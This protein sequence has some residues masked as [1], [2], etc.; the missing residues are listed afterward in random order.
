MTM[1]RL[2]NLLLLSISLALLFAACGDNESITDPGGQN[3][4]ILLLLENDERFT[5][6][7]SLI[8]E[9]GLADLMSSDEL[10]VFAPTNT[11]FEELFSDLNPDDF[12]QEDVVEIVRYHLLE[13]SINSGDLQPMQE[14]T[15]LNIGLIYVQSENDAILINGSSSVIE[16]DI[17]A[18]NGVIHSVDKVFI[19][20]T[21]LNVIEAAQKNYNFTT[22]IDLINQADLANTI[23]TSEITVFVPTNDAFDALFSLGELNLTVEEITELVLYHTIPDNKVL[24]SN[25]APEQTVFSGTG[26]ELYITSS[27]SGV[28]V[29]GFKEVISADVQAKNGVMHALNL[30]L[31]PNKYWSTIGLLQKN[32]NYTT[33]LGL[34]Y[35]TALQDDLLGSTIFAPTNDAFDS[36]YSILEPGSFNLQEKAELVQYHFIPGVTVFSADFAPEQTVDP[37]FTEP[38]YL[39]MDTEGVVINGKSNVII[40]DVEARVGVVHAVDNV[41]LPN[42]F[43]NVGDILAKNYNLTDITDQLSLRAGDLLESP[44][45]LTVF[46]PAN[47]AY[48]AYQ[49][50]FDALTPEQKAS[51][52]QYH[53]ID[54]LVLSTELSPSQSVTM[55]NDQNVTITASN[56]IITIDAVNSTA[57]L[58][59]ADLEGLNGVVHII[60]T[61]LIPAL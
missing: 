44:G 15:M 26:E 13:G 6:L 33:F 30:P 28:V 45:P 59:V 41:L 35:Q 1:N 55:V 24:T 11:A 16:P 12:T 10:T 58:T 52:I 60:D 37:A 56:G 27:S 50:T 36:L 47:D 54:A 4:D 31:L 42:A 49:A 39:T 3:S 40:P 22:F 14:I 38:L 7:V 43:L 48:Q 61:M 17:A 57:T 46:A 53:M 34:V 19:P 51:V 29:N 32:Y 20:N 9:A 25:L 23:A 5:T 21:F 18:V 8:Q 2:L